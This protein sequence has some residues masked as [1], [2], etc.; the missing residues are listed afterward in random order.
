MKSLR[1]L[2]AGLGCLLLL[3]LLLLLLPVSAGAVAD[4]PREL[5]IDTTEKMLA[6]IRE[7]QEALDANPR[8][9]DEFIIDIVL[10]HFDFVAMSR[11]VLGKHWRRA[12][13]G[14]Q[15]RFV[16]E[17]RNLLVRTYATALLEYT[18]EPIDYPPL[19]ANPTDTD[20]TV[21][22]EIEQPGGLGIPINYRMERLDDGW[23]VYDITID[24]LSLISNY[25]NT[26]NNEIRKVGI[27]RLIENIKQRNA[28]AHG[29]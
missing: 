20:V 15:E 3:L 12:S 26:F 23:K 27:D 2:V 17:F 18:E 29:G 28:D 9:V 11:A 4:N 8:M 6:K 24:G 19:I 21:R 16:L 25:R 10:P 5:V 7:Q 1:S 22:T 14:Q 13:A